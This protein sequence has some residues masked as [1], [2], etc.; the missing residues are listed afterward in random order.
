MNTSNNTSVNDSGFKT[1]LRLAI[2]DF[3]DDQPSM[4]SAP[5]PLFLNENESN[6]KKHEDEYGLN[7]GVIDYSFSKAITLDEALKQAG[8]F[9][10]FQYMTF[11]VFCLSF[12]T[13]GVVVY[14]I[15][16]MQATPAYQCYPKTINNVESQFTQKD[17]SFACVP[18]QFC[19]NPNMVHE[20]DYTSPQT[21]LN[22]ITYFNLHCIDKVQLGLMGT[23]IF[24]GYT[25]SC[26]ILPRMADTYG[27]K[28]IFRGFYV[29]HAIGM[30]I[31]LFVPHQLAIYIGLFFVGSASTI[32]TSVG[33]VYGLEFIETSKQNLAGTLLKTIDVMT[34]ILFSVLFMTITNN[35][36][37]YYYVGLGISIFAWL[38]SFTIPESPSLLISQHKFIEAREVIKQ[39][40]LVNG[41]KNFQFKQLFQ[42]EVDYLIQSKYQDDNNNNTTMNMTRNNENQQ[43]RRN[44]QNKTV[45]R[46]L[47]DRNIKRNLAILS[48]CWMAS[49]FSYYL[50]LFYMKYLPGNI[51]ENTIFCSSADT[52]GYL[53]TGILFQ[54]VGGR[55]SLIISFSLAAISSFCIVNLRYYPSLVPIFLFGSRLGIAAACNV[56]TIVNILVFPADFRSTSFGICNIFA[57]MA[58]IIAPLAAELE[59]PYPYMLLITIT[60]IYAIISFYLS[61]NQSDENAEFKQ[62]LLEKVSKKKQVKFSGLHLDVEKSGRYNKW[63]DQDGKLSSNLIKSFSLPAM[64]GGI[65][66]F[67]VLQNQEQQQYMDYESNADFQ[68]VEEYINTSLK[69]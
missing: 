27:R 36:R 28:I 32:R 1:K 10:R 65:G 42:Q 12:W 59:Y 53:F 23:S 14:I 41:V 2:E 8:G 35:W 56:L 39:I 37:Y 64:F 43:Q 16:F 48:G 7:V 18:D 44:S 11:F 60:S 33:Y 61:D 47:R 38:C 62:R 5:M 20:V 21:I 68:D 15:H 31:I 24:V 51:F 30:A 57:R 63:R 58:A 55:K 9:G 19:N 13:G 4:L 34:P 17:Q 29:F 26:F 25:I 46:Y 54:Y 22:Y 66:N 52:A 67:S 3:G 6:L 40:A 49:T 50:V 45:A 69:I